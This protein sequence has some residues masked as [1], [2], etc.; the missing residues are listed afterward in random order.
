MKFKKRKTFLGVDDFLW[1]NVSQQKS[2]RESL[3]SIF[4]EQKLLK[5]FRTNVV[6]FNYFIIVNKK[7]LTN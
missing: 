5:V 7:K 1:G 2:T 3:E 4:G 6:I